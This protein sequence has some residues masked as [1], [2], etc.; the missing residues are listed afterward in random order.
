MIV[1][2][3][4]IFAVW[5]LATNC[6]DT[7]LGSERLSVFFCGH[8]IFICKVSG[9]PFFAVCG[10]VYLGASALL[11]AVCG[12]IYFMIGTYFFAAC[13][14]MGALFFAMLGIILSAFAILRSCWLRY[15]FQKYHSRMSELIVREKAMRRSGNRLAC[16][17]RMMHITSLS[18]YVFC[19][20]FIQ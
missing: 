4:K 18:K 15:S 2:N 9:V 17:L 20:V 1:V 8:V 19:L 3:R 6:T 12:V 13:G 7:V 10:A 11:F 5:R 16:S 14:T